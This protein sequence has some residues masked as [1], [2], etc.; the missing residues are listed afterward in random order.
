MMLYSLIE[1]ESLADPEL[2]SYCYIM[3]NLHKNNKQYTNEESN[4]L[5]V[6]AVEDCSRINDI[7][8]PYGDW[9]NK[10]RVK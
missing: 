3:C 6:A 7:S 9:I 1:I 2:E 10:R 5:W 4:A 8:T